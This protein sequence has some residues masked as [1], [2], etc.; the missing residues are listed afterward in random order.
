VY[1]LVP[2]G[3]GKNFQRQALFY[4]LLLHK[5]KNILP[6]KNGASGSV[7]SI[8]QAV[9]EYYQVKVSDLKSPRR[10]KGFSHPRQIAMYLCKKHLKVS[11]PE[12]G[13]KFGGK[14]H[15]TVI[16]ACR[17]IEGLLEQDSNLQNDIA[18]LERAILH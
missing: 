3:Q 4:N 8:Q 14:D 12:L 1:R 9:A 17:K 13:H 16:H 5:K 15:T 7:E 18:I 2:V 10:M 11:F 6:S